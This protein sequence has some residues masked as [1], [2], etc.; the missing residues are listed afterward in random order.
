MVVVVVDLGV[1]TGTGI[2]MGVQGGGHCRSRGTGIGMGT[3]VAG[4]A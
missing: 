1:D 4:F 3:A 2:R